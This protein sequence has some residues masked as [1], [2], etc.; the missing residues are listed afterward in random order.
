[1]FSGNAPDD[2]NYFCMSYLHRSFQLAAVFAVLLF[3]CP[4]FAQAADLVL[5]PSTGSYSSGQTFT[6]TIRAVPN[7]QSVNAVETTLNFNPD[8]LSVVSVDRDGSVFSLW[9][10]EPE[11]SNSAGTIEFGGGSPSPFTT[12]SNL[13]SVT[14]RTVGEG[15]GSVEFTEA[16][17]LV[18]DGQGT[19]VF[20]DSTGASYTITQASTP[21]PTPTPTPTEPD[22]PAEGGEDDDAIIFGDPPRQPELGSQTFL[23]P[24]TWYNSTDGVFT[25]TLP[26]DVNAV[27]VEVSDDPENVPEENEDAIIDPPVEEF[28][29]S[30]EVVTD[31]EQY[32]SINFRNQ[33]GWGAVTNR[34]LRI[35]TTPPEEFAINIRTGT[36]ES[37][38]PLL[39][40]EANDLTSGIDYYEL[41]IADAEPIRI[42]PREAEL[43]YLLGDLEDGT[44]TVKVVATDMAGNTRESSEAVL[45]TAGWDATG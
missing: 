26:F 5:S 23:E 35:D 43:G 20:A 36:T 17:V 33:V 38:F 39:N 37:S 3:L 10:T 18:A 12:T 8:V 41:T 13:L 34:R 45:I 42:T 29:V 11:F 9:T 1:M 15:T 6:A 30:D 21:T 2:V 25:W 27:A 24:D 44:Y 22:A 16:S 31:G 40:F 4:L 7:G 28:V 32:V 19:D 14:F